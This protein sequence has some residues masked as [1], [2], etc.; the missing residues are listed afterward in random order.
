MSGK[1]DR[2]PW[3]FLPFSPA[4]LGRIW[5]DYWYI[6]VVCGT[7]VFGF[8]WIVITFL[9]KYNLRYRL[10]MVKNLPQILKGMIGQDILEII[11]YTGIT[12]FAYI[13]P[14]SLAI[15]I[16]FAAMVP[17][18]MLAG[19]IDTGTIELLLA[20]PLS[21]RKIFGTTLLASLVGGALLIGSMLLG[22]WMGVSTTKLTEPVELGRILV[23]ALNLYALYVVVMSASMLFGSIFSFR[24][25]AV[26]WTVG[27][28]VASYLL[29]FLSEWWPF[30]AKI[31]FLGPL[32]YFR[33]IKIAAGGYDSRWDI[34]TLKVILAGAYD[35]RRDITVL[36]AASA[37][38]LIF[39]AIR[40]SRRDIAVL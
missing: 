15:L 16:G 2:I 4:L 40:F 34:T 21:R 36:L 33:P 5:R 9:P 19:Q 35:P 24:S 26:G 18:W 13:H 10:Y 3:R 6:G 20:T 30:V 17:T 8:H 31:S 32:Y 7:T 22:T 28:A 27:V 23:V 1:F 14:V 38:L 39:A 37:V 25:L 29:H 12:S 11:S